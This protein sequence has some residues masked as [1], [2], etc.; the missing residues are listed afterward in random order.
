MTDSD[1]K[2][3]RPELDWPAIRSLAECNAIKRSGDDP[4]RSGN[5]PFG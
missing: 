2:S 5:D 3:R 4:F 1:K